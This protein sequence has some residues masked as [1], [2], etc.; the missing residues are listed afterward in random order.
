MAYFFDNFQQRV[1]KKRARSAPP[2]RYFL[3][4]PTHCG[5]YQDSYRIP[6]SY[7][8]DRIDFNYTKEE[9]WTVDYNHWYRL[10][11]AHLERH[12]VGQAINSL[13]LIRRGY[14]EKE[15]EEIL[16]EYL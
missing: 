13:V 5:L 15:F 8:G 10:L 9:S 2:E 12:G 6:E 16:K 1:V 7:A 4:Y 14:P 11:Q 3:I